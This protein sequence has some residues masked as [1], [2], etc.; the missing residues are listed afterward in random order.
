M[1]AAQCSVSSSTKPP[2]NPNTLLTN[3]LSSS[4]QRFFFSC[5]V[6]SSLCF[7]LDYSLCPVPTALS[8][9][10]NRVYSFAR[11]PS[12]NGF[13]RRTNAADSPTKRLSAVFSTFFFSFLFLTTVP[14]TNNP[15]QQQ[16]NHYLNT[17]YN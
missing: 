13:C 9:F 7:A 15:T 3:F 6:L 16:T 14:A 17:L 4:K 12:T 2:T 1:F 11:S 5:H 10:N 8:R